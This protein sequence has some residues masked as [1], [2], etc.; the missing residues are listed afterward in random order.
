MGI[1]KVRRNKK[2]AENPTVKEYRKPPTQPETIAKWVADSEGDFITNDVV[3]AFPKFNRR[4]IEKVLK[5][6]SDN[7]YID[8]RKCVCGCANVYRLKDTPNAPEWT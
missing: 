4:V 6:F 7:N 5:R 1:S 8:S 2:L 3:K